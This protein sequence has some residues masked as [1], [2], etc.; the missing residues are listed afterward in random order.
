MARLNENQPTNINQLNVVNFEVN[1][2]RLPA[3]QYFCQ[4]VNIPAVILGSTF[5]PSSFLNIPVEGETLNFEALNI[6]FILDED[7]KNYL[8][9][10][11]WLTSLGFPKDFSQFEGLQ[12]ASEASAYASMFSDMNIIINT[13]KSNPNF[14]VT[15][16]DVFPTS[17][18][19][20][21]F[22]TSN[23]S[24]EPIVVEASFNFKGMFEISKLV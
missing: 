16:Q 10:Y 6:S 15:F 4:R 11:D 14:K 19:D 2:S 22:D 1:F 12:P 5:Q 9:I 17:L 8:E 23:T 21:Q 3:A 20:I 18:S 13:N 24:L 7:L